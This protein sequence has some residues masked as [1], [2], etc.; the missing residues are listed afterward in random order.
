MP[1]KRKRDALDA[2]YRK[3][4]GLQDGDKLPKALG[5]TDSTGSARGGRG[6]AQKGKGRNR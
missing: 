3:A 6:A 4:L 5:Q 2:A 1:K